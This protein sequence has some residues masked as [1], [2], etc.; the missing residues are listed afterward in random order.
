MCTG[1]SPGNGILAATR[2]GRR[3]SRKRVEATAFCS[4]AEPTVVGQAYAVNVSVT[5]TTGTPTGTVTVSDG[6][7]SCTIT[8]PA[9]SCN[10]TGI[11]PGAKT[12]NATYNGDANFGAS[13]AT[14]PHTVN[15]T[16]TT[17][18]ITN[19]AALGTMT[20][21]G[22]SYA[23][24]ASVSITAPGAGTLS[25]TITVSDGSQVCTI[26]LPASSCT[27]TSTLPGA[28]TITATYNGDTNFNNSTST[29]VS[30]TVNK[31]S[32]TTVINNAAALGTATVAGQSY[33]V[34]ASVSITAPGAGTLSG[35][36]TVSDGSQTCTITL[37]ATSCN[38]TSAS[39]GA[40][41][42][43]T[44]AY[45]GDA[46]F[47]GSS[48]TTTHT[49]NKANTTAALLSDTLDPSVVGQSVTVTYSIS[50]TSPGGGT[51]TGNVLLVMV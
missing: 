38:L 35:T 27:L 37:P 2:L 20:V 23:V 45:N 25:G 34:Q 4:D 33:S 51:P 26:T 44:A 8:L 1:S 21:V 36:I 30:H 17:T 50:V 24:D 49:L 42:T 43:I 14:T 28:K 46:S 22:Q 48:A 5:A 10:L 39:P 13:S 19:A 16:N 15:K 12:I 7:Q 31:A 41:K 29:G 11:S 47:G 32:T 9:T 3:A 6:A 40:P 18:V